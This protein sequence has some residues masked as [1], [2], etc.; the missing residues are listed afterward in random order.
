MKIRAN[1]LELEV[2]DTASADPSHRGRPAVLLIMGLGMQL[3]AWPPQMVQALVAHF[4]KA[5]SLA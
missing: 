1:Q 4:Q 2:E 5:Q 3:I